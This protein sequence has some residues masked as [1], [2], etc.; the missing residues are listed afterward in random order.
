MDILSGGELR[1]LRDT[2]ELGFQ[3]RLE[4]GDDRGGVLATGCKADAGPAARGVWVPLGVGGGR[5]ESA[6]LSFKLLAPRGCPPNGRADVCDAARNLQ[7]IAMPTDKT[8]LEGTANV[9]PDWQAG[10]YEWWPS[11]DRLAWS[12]ELVRLYGLDAAP[13]SERDFTGL[14]HPDDRVR[15]EAETSAFLGSDAASY[16]HS[17][18]IVRPDGAVRVILD[19]SAIE[20]DP[21]G[22]VRRIRGLNVDVTDAL[23]VDDTLPDAPEGMRTNDGE[24]PPHGIC[25]QP[26]HS[27]ELPSASDLSAK[28]AMLESLF[29]VAEVGLGIWD[30]DFRFVHINPALAAINGL[31]VEAHLGRR[32][33]EIL[34][35]LADYDALYAAWRRVLETG[36][37]WRGVQISGETPAEPGRIRHWEEDFF[38]VRVGGRIA[39]LAAVVQETTRRDAAEARSRASESR[40]RAL[41]DA[42]D[43]GF[44]IVEV[45]LDA[46]DGRIDYRVVEANPA[47]YACTGFPEA[48]LG[49]WLREAAPDLEEHWYE[50]YGSVAR[51]GAPRRFEEKSETLGRWF[52]VYAFPIDAPE[53]G[54]VAILFDD[55]SER[56]R[57]EERSEMLL[58]ELNHR[59]KN[60]LGL[61]QSIAR[62]TAASGAADFTTRFGERL[63]ALGAAQDLLVHN[64]WTTVPLAD[65]VAAQLAHFSDLFGTRIEMDGPPL[66]L[67]PDA[68][69]T[70]GMALHE[71]ATN[72]AKYGALSNADGCISVLWRV[73]AEVGH[74]PRF[75][76]NWQERGGPPV[77]EPAEQGFGAKVTTRMVKTDTRGEVTLDYA[78]AGLSWRLSCPAGAVLDRSSAARATARSG[79]GS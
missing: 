34:P 17:F 3:P 32:P 68:T 56:K 51:T 44:C 61:I 70:L 14:I 20:R 74:E 23:G 27:T 62:Q 6:L 49:R 18:R 33:D 55:I 63:M 40:Y 13:H 48:I 29:D 16:S 43:E 76:L 35:D 7:G 26:D 22:N 36:E 11:E 37:P 41:F 71:L 73:E 52:D 47:F 10:T 79:P 77:A 38:P 50:I 15:V 54:R 31:P 53:T 64:D 67:M 45:C 60:M 28:A 25:S 9:E 78:P 42:I 58:H 4:R 57:Q 46:P 69:Q 66:T 21:A 72:A 24:A 65:L 75:T 19:R 39:G 30:A 8:A 1:L 5:L 2:G 59:S 12:P